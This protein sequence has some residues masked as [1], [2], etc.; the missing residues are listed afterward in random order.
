MMEIQKFYQNNMTWIE[1]LHDTAIGGIDFNVIINGGV[2]CKNYSSP[3]RRM[4]EGFVAIILSFI[5]ITISGQLDGSKNNVHKENNILLNGNNNQQNGVIRRKTGVD[6][7]HYSEFLRTSL[8]FVYILVNGVELG[9]KVIR[10][11]IC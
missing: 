7:F 2:E 10:F 5:S 11:I 8:L 6:I 4:V 9:Y 1:T 3:Y